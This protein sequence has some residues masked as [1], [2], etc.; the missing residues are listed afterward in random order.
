LR[1]R[2]DEWIELGAMEALREKVL[3]AYDRVRHGRRSRLASSF[4]LFR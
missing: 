4:A 3:A 2:R 1:Q